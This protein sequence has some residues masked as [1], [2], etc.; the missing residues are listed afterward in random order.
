MAKK[1]EMISGAVLDPGRKEELEPQSVTDV[2]ETDI[3][4]EVFEDLQKLLTSKPVRVSKVVGREQ[5]LST[6]Q[7]NPG[8]DYTV[9]G[10]LDVR[11]VRNDEAHLSV[12]RAGQWVFP[13]TISPRLKNIKHN[14]LVLM[15]RLMEQSK[16]KQKYVEAESRKFESES[17]ANTPAARGSALSEFSVTKSQ[18]HAE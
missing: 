12:A 6:S 10:A 7:H 13:E 8:V 3:N 14:E 11:W 5:A 18:K 17:F 4:A 15:V 1:V 16:N 9:G 2:D